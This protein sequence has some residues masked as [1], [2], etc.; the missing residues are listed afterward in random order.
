[1]FKDFVENALTNLRSA[2]RDDGLVYAY[3]MA[4]PLKWLTGCVLA[5]ISAHLALHLAELPQRETSLVALADAVSFVVFLWCFL[6]LVCKQ[7]TV[8]MVHWLGTVVF[9]T[10]VANIITSEMI[11]RQT[12]DIVYMPFVVIGVGAILLA[13]IAYVVAIACML[14]VCIPTLCL[15]VRPQNVTELTTMFFAGICISASV[16]ASRIR[17]YRRISALRQRDR[18]Q[19]ESLQQ[20]LMTVE[21]Q[22]RGHRDMQ[23]RRQNL[24]DQLRQA[25]KLEAI[26]V[27]A[28]GVAH[29][30]NNVLGAI[31]SVASLAVDRVAHDEQLRQDLADI[32]CAARRGSTLTRNLLGFARQ[33]THVRER[34]QLGDTVQSVMR[35]MK[36]TVSKQVELTH[37]VANDLDDIQ[38]DAG[39][40]GHVLMNLCINGVDAI[41]GNGRL[42][43]SVTNRQVAEATAEK[44]EI[45]AGSYIELRVE[46]TGQGI[47]ADVLPRVFEPFFSTKSRNER[48][49]L[50]LSMVYGTV[51]EYGGAISIQS[52]VGH[53]TVVM[54]LLPSLKP[55]VAT[56]RP[57]SV[58]P[59]P[60][61]DQYRSVLLVDDEPML[62]AAGKRLIQ[63]MGFDVIT[64]ANGAEAAV[65]YRTHQEEIVLVV[66]DVA[67]PVM[68]G[69]ECFR[70]L[71]EINPKVSV[72][73][74]TG[75]AKHGDV[76]ALLNEG[77]VGY[78]GKPYDRRELERAVRQALHLAHSA[79]MLVAPDTPLPRDG[80]S[81]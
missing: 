67:M 23:Q 4:E 40:M 12:I 79:S 48:S 54:V 68:S 1:M 31:T 18:E 34:F 8:R 29:D 66:L 37:S 77:A 32:L 35:L 14:L 28:G 63:A 57:A 46:D 5:I 59:P 15:V 70:R 65:A 19:T 75:Y 39:Q 44:L 13:P 27:L 42:H 24:E 6:R 62:R 36:S 51:K 25:Q 17:G 30:M 53:G 47:A 50:G 71:R 78:L 38:G 3:S 9:V 21:E 60:Q 20:A 7:P 33:G 26:G 22:L 49:G 43:V 10:L 56:Q 55:Q 80:T 69:M 11:R 64:A 73:I 45:D 72:L 41:V 52:L 58:N 76:D 81:S 74:A 2:S 61:L 16:V